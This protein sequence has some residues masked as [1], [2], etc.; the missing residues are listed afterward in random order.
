MKKPFVSLFCLGITIGL[1]SSQINAQ[2]FLQKL[3]EK[4][5]SVAGGSGT[6]AKPSKAL[7][8]KQR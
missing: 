1:S 5:E 2:G 3:K 7:Y 4:A 8:E 6:G